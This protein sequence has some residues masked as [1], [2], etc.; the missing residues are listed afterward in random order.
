M[1][2]SWDHITTKSGKFQGTRLIDNLGDAYETLEQCYGMIQWLAEQI[3][4]ETNSD[5][6]AVI[7]DAQAHYKDGLATGG[8]AEK[9]FSG[10]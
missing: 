6:P 4:L 9:R 1:A 3:A 2:G 10:E 8:Q 5:R 7:V